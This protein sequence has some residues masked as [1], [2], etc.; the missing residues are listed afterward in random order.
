MR[1]QYAFTCWAELAR[2][3]QGVS[4]Q[5]GT[6]IRIH[7]YKRSAGLRKD[8]DSINHFGFFPAFLETISSAQRAVKSRKC[9]YETL[10]T[11]YGQ[12]VA[13]VVSGKSNS[14]SLG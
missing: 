13:T 5:R 7:V 1:V 9:R 12:P 3:Q 14:N 2:E 11:Q 4:E 8:P 10:I 6:K